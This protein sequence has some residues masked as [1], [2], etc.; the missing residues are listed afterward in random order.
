MNRAP[1]W[2][3]VFWAPLL[4]APSAVGAADL[5]EL[6]GQTVT[7]VQVFH[8]GVA[9]D[10]QGILDLVETRTGQPLSLREVRESVTHLFTRGAYADVQVTAL[11]TDGGIFLRYDLV[12]LG[13][14]G[15]VE[16]RGEF[17]L[18]RDELLG[19]LRRRFGRVVR[20]DQVPSAVTLLE[21]VYLAAG[22][23]SARITPDADGGRLVFD[24]DQ[25][26]VAR[27][28]HV[29][30]RGVEEGD[31]ERVLERL[32]VAEGA[33]YDP[34]Q[35]EARLA[36]YEAEIRERRYYEARFRHD[37]LPSPDGR[38]V[39]LLLDIQTG[40]PVEIQVDGDLTNAPLDELVPVAREGS[41]DE[42]LLEDSSLRVEMYLRGLGYR[43][44][45]VTHRR[46]VQTGLLSVV[47][48]VDRGPEYR[49]GNVTITG[50]ETISVDD[51]AVG[52]GVFSG[53]PLVAADV[54]AG[55]LAIRSWYAERGHRDVQV[56]PRLAER[57][58]EADDAR[59]GVVS[60]DVT[61]EI[62]E[63]T[64]TTVGAV[65]FSGNG[66]FTA[67]ALAALVDTQVGVPYFAPR[68]AA[69]RER[70]RAHYLNEGYETVQ[71]DVVERFEDNGT[72]VNV[73]FQLTEGVQVVVDHVLVV[74]TNQVSPST[75]RSEMT[76]RPGDPL[77]LDEV[78]E[79]RRRLTA[80]GLF[81]R[82]DIRELSHGGGNRRDVVVD[83]E[84]APATR[85]GYGGGLEVNQRLRATV[86]GAAAERLELAPRGFFEVGRRNLW[87]K[88]RSIDLFT[89]VSVRRKDDLDADTAVSDL[90]FNEY[91]VLLN[92]REPRAFG[93]TG[94]LLVSG[95][96][97]QVIR[98]SFDLFSR[99][100][101]AELR[102][103]IGLTMTGSAGYTYGQNRVTNGQFQ[104]EEGPLVDRLF[105]E[106]TLSTFSGG[107]VLDSR[108]DP[109]EPT[110]GLLVGVDAEGA[111]RNLGSEVGFVK[112]SVQGFFFQALPG[113]LVFAAGARL[114]LAR[115][116]TLML[117]TLPIFVMTADGVLVQQG[118]S[119]LAVIQD[120]PA[121]ERFFA[122]GDT[123]VRGFA[124]DRLG[125][126]TTIDPNGFPTG[127]NAMI[128]MN[129]ELRVPVSRAIQVV[130]FLD[131]GNV[132][133][134]VSNLDLNR[135]R[136]AA[137]FGVRYRSPVGPIRVDLGF[138]LDRREFAGEQEPLTALH[139]SIGQAF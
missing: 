101:N 123:T 37:V 15:G 129:S 96:V 75:V 82:I 88:N 51:L 128:V 111:F 98:P 61:V 65:G 60:V 139:F 70:L 66:A 2:C 35:L 97:E 90:G 127:G 52:F 32:G 11:K 133:D 42:D 74:G 106:V 110:R 62:G 46:T 94:D 17:G 100:V 20:P 118:G 29:D 22:R 9:T 81:R 64:E 47:F 58:D 91:R 132:F 136:G 34:R 26:P 14:T 109:L 86:G 83:V 108:D 122:G 21:E 77:G 57:D 68:L 41:I 1:L 73:M 16:I 43:D 56:V 10:D 137:G 105:P 104:N 113:E 89:R 19:A 76:L 25:G 67:S 138:K 7:R 120:L 13:A 4:C 8:A 115:G 18:P 114:G 117:P 28:G 107:L 134:R 44:A 36:E 126:A 48:A 3:L 95:F 27:I 24:I 71:V 33:V 31:P 12:P 23:F 50:Q 40:S 112:A 130:G 39:D 135:I 5:A 84:E 85:V 54:D 59:L 79:T 124:L 87:G 53:A 30:V 92:Y 131:A 55:V 69:D 102:R 99:G 121:S 125:D 78:A 63:G 38:T 116:F 45:R 93:R 72:T 6:L 119:A 80:L 49:V 103:T